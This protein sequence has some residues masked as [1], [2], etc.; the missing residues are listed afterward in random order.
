MFI[1]VFIW[2]IK[3]RIDC[4][5]YQNTDCIRIVEPI[6]CATESTTAIFGWNY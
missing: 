3:E 2:S 1:I 4:I 6:A 5:T